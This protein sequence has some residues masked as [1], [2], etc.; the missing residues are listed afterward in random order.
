[1]HEL[2]RNIYINIKYSRIRTHLEGITKQR[3]ALEPMSNL[4]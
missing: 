2:L 3:E 1:M 4:N